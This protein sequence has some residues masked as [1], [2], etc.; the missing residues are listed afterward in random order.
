[1]SNVVS[2]DT[3]RSKQGLVQIRVEYIDWNGHEDFICEGDIHWVKSSLCRD[4][5]DQELPRRFK[6]EFPVIDV[7]E[8]DSG[9]EFWVSIAQLGYLVEGSCYVASNDYPYEF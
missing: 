9:R 3:Y 7:V 1:M 4:Y 8:L 5:Y 2:L 6:Y